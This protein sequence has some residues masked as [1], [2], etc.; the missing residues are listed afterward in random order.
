MADERIRI[1]AELVGVK[2]GINTLDEL[3]KAVSELNNRKA[4]IPVDIA[5][6]RKSMQEFNDTA[7]KYHGY[8]VKMAK[9]GYAGLSKIWEGRSQ[10]LKVQANAQKDIIRN[11][12]VEKALNK[13]ALDYADQIGKEWKAN[14]TLV[15]KAALAEDRAWKQVYANREKEA[16]AAEKHERDLM[17]LQHD[18][19][20]AEKNAWDRYYAQQEQ[21]RQER[22]QRTADGFR[23]LTNGFANAFSFT[24]D[25]SRTVGNTFS[26]M[27]SLFNTNFVDV[28]RIKLSSMFQNMIMGNIG[29][30]LSRADIMNTFIPY[31]TLSGVTEEDAQAALNRVDLSIRGLPIGLDEAAQR[32]RRYQM[33]L[34]DTQRATD[35]T[36]GIQ[37][38]ITAGGAP[39]SFKTQAY[40]MIDRLLTAG[41]L[42]TSR[43]WYSLING[44]GVSVRFL[45]EAMGVGK[46]TAAEFAAGLASKKYSVEQFLDAIVA[47]G[48]GTA[49]SAAELDKALNIYKS[50][51]ESWL[52]NIRFAVV[53]GT[54]NVINAMDEVLEKGTG[55]KIIGYMEDFRDGINAIFSGA[56]EWVKNNPEPIVR[57]VNAVTGLVDAFKGSGA[58][59]IVGGILNNFARVLEYIGGLMGRIGGGTLGEFISFAT[60]IAGPVGMVMTKLAGTLP[61][62]LGVFQRFKDFDFGSFIDRILA[63]V[64]TFANIIE[65]FFR[66]LPNEW[67]SNLMAFALVWGKPLATAIKAV[68]GAL[69][70]LGSG[71]L[72]MNITNI[73]FAVHGLIDAFKA[74]F[75]FLATNPIGW[76]IDVVIGVV[77]A[78][79]AVARHNKAM[80]EAAESTE[81]FLRASAAV[82]A[83][84]NIRKASEDTR[85]SVSDTVGEMDEQ[86]QKTKELVAELQSLNSEVIMTDEVQE[87]MA[88]I[89]S[90]LNTLYPDWNLGVDNSTK[91][92]D[93]H[94]KAVLSNVDA[95]LAMAKAEAVAQQIT[96]LYSTA[97]ENANQRS[98]VRIAIA[99]AEG[100]SDK[101]SR[102]Y[103]KALD[104]WRPILEAEGLTESDIEARVKD[105]PYVLDGVTTTYGAALASEAESLNKLKQER[106]DLVKEDENVQRDIDHYTRLLRDL[107]NEST[108]AEEALNSFAEGNGRV[109]NAVVDTSKDLAELA[110]KYR[111]VKEA[112]RD[113]IDSQLSG[114]EE[115]E[116]FKPADIKTI[117]ERLKANRERSELYVRNQ[118]KLY[119]FDPTLAEISPAAWAGFALAAEEGGEEYVAGVASAID[120]ALKSGNYKPIQDAF[121]EWLGLDTSNARY[122]EDRANM[123]MYYGGLMGEQSTIVQRAAQQALEETSDTVAVGVDE[124]IQKI[125]E[126]RYPLQKEAWLLGQDIAQIIKGIEDSE[127]GITAAIDNLL[128]QVE[129][130]VLTRKQAIVA[131]FQ[132]IGSAAGQ[133]VQYEVG[134]TV[135]RGPIRRERFAR[136]GMVY[137][138]NGMFIPRG[139]DTVPAMLTPGEFVVNRRATQTIG[140]SILAQIN[141]LDIPGALHSLMHRIP[142]MTGSSIVNNTSTRDNHAKVTQNFYNSSDDGFAY[143]RANRFVRALV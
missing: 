58:G 107:N 102:D 96:S 130:G 89:I 16:Q 97:F 26:N 68:G 67:W 12:N 84:E 25:L 104:T 48:N 81:S 61:L 15:E 82:D 70:A 127:P 33:F 73:T 64:Q 24:A 29:A 138:A 53:R 132:E 55:K 93:A 35:L 39:E 108:G 41:T 128:A 38:A 113:S 129:Q 111:E 139:S 117:I 51:F 65:S 109:Q 79:A 83:T 47:L 8:S 66:I 126:H 59:N 52:S 112:A 141:R 136:G 92:L 14:S 49:S 118:Q 133:L 142:S 123:E 4:T 98:K 60:T 43:Q 10:D 131:A 121:R 22:I 62:L 80:K 42:S 17:V 94:T 122:A 86:A 5:N 137:A 40:Y 101:V 27:A 45:S 116:E 99:M 140:A 103:Q 50:T 56:A 18:A 31:M 11:L 95:I 71:K 74:L 36:I 106:D 135:E 75:V 72:G 125:E 87:R 6:A 115:L 23:M 30:A 9:D 120:A 46:I 76:L 91:H 57:V 134:R 78:T 88:E 90:Q 54:T 3:K 2:E 105:E 63:H 85:K 44:L 19:V 20:T 77:A 1:I 32:L 34:G 119:E 28:A 110:D 69:I 124:I 37:K 143:R 100:S 13:Q 7:K 114:F 21:E